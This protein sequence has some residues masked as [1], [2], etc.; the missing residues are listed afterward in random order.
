M[1]NDLIN[2]MIAALKEEF[3]DIPVYDELV[4]QGIVE[5][6]FFVRCVEPN[7]RL[8]RGRRYFQKNMMEVVYFP[9]KENRYQNSNDV[10]ESLFGCLEILS[11]PDGL[12]RGRNMNVHTN[13]DYTVIFTVTYSDFLYTEEK[14]EEPMGTLIHLRHTDGETPTMM[15]PNLTDEDGRILTEEQAIPMIDGEKVLG[16]PTEI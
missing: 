7:R 2:G 10:V 14:Q 13:A 3:P 5:P 4:N 16:K 1:V 9:P 8:F 6:S 11:L 12:I 15:Y